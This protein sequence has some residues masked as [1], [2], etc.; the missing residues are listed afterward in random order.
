MPACNEN[1]LQPTEP[2]IFKG[3]PINAVICTE[4]FI[5]DWNSVTTTRAHLVLQNNNFI[6]GKLEI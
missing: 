5:T 3:P 6:R 1:A 2:P 4:H